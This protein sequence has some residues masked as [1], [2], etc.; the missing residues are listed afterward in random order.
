MTRMDERCF[1][2]QPAGIG[3]AT[4]FVEACCA[5][6]GVARDDALRLALITEELFTNTVMH[7]HGGGSDATVR[8]TLRIED[9]EMLLDYSDEAA[10]FDPLA[11]TDDAL[12][13]L[14]ADP[15]ARK[16]GGLGV[17]LVVQLASRIRYER[18]DGRNCLSVALAR[19][20][21]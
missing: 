9:S 10:A 18:V 6:S 5:R 13:P 12:A 7:G 8:I 1:V 16:P 2:A 4:A 17:L 20:S 14:D 3:E 11:R 19:A 21:G 15:D